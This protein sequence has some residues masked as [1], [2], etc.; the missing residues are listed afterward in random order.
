[1][2]AEVD[3][4]E[5]HCHLDGAVGSCWDRERP[6]SREGI[7]LTGPCPG[8]EA[9]SRSL[10]GWTGQGDRLLVPAVKGDAADEALTSSV[11]CDE[12]F[13]PIPARVSAS[14]VQGLVLWVPF[15]SNG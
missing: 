10:V 6:M 14:R 15:L 4:A 5:M 7:T 12:V 8:S 1:M 13:P 2:E 3:M 11:A 9:Q